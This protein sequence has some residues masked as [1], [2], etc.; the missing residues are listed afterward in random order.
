VH[1]VSCLARERRTTGERPS[2]F[3]LWAEY[4]R[5]CVGLTGCCLQGAAEKSGPLKFFAV[6]SATVWNFN[7]KFYGFIY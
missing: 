6:F 5:R 2:A 4:V 3:V 1:R 7:L